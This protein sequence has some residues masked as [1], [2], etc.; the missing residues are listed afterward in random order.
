MGSY[1]AARFVPSPDRAEV[2]DA[3]EAAW[4]A[5]WTLVL[6]TVGIVLALRAI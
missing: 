6:A 1:D 5:D 2:G 3:R 4:I